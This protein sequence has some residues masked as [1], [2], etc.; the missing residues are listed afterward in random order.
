MC[1]KFRKPKED[2]VGAERP[3]DVG[4]ISDS[5]PEEDED[6]VQNRELAS[7][8]AGI[9]EQGQKKEETKGEKKGEHHTNRLQSQ[10]GGEA[11]RWQ[12]GGGSVCP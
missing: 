7:V 2:V 8:V 6:D 5:P 9:A 10:N 1:N 3:M 4:P 11:D 12:M